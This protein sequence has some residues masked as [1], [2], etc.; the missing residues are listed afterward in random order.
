MTFPALFYPAHDLALAHG[1]RHFTPPAVAVQLQNDLEALASWWQPVSSS[2][3][4]LPWG[5]NYET[6][7]SLLRAGVGE[8]FLPTLQELTAL[9]ELSSRQTTIVLLQQIKTAAEKRHSPAFDALRPPR[10]LTTTEE[11]E[12]AIADNGSPFLLKAPWSSSG[13]GLCWSRMTPPELLLKRGNSILREMKCVLLEPEYPKIQDFAMLFYIGGQEVQSVGYSL[14]DT[15]VKGTYQ[16]GRIMSN[17]EMEQ[18]LGQ[19]V[20][21]RTLRALADLYRT[22]ILPPLFARFFNRP[23]HLGYVGIDMMIYGDGKRPPGLHPCIELNLR[24][25]M[26]VVARQIFDRKVHPASAGRFFITHA[27]DAAALMAEHERLTRDFPPRRTEEQF[28]SGYI[29]LTPI[30]NESRFAAYLLLE[31]SDI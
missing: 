12:S 21:V 11:L 26:G 4:P 24:C 15:D 2:A 13:R 6:R 8:S 25:T 3:L 20:P 18:Y 31:T 1:I 27:K 16:S 29:P 10:L 14:F 22:A 28:I 30:R 5:W 9:R 19:W 17:D 23:Y 7:Q